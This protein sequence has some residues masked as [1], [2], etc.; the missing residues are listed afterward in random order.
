MA[1]R[2]PKQGLPEKEGCSGSS[3]GGVKPAAG[4]LKDFH[5]W[6][7]DRELAGH[8]RQLRLPGMLQ[9]LAPAGENLRKTENAGRDNQRSPCRLPGE[10]SFISLINSRNEGCS[11][12]TTPLRLRYTLANSLFQP[13]RARGCCFSI[14][15]L[16]CLSCF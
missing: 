6:A 4:V 2:R 16:L 10:Y 13:G 14:A 8:W 3:E 15:T 9:V 1:A 7:T 11:G 5:A 12:A